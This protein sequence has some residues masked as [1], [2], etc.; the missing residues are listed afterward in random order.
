MVKSPQDCAAG[1][2]LIVIAVLAFLSAWPLPFQQGGGIGSGMLP[3]A[4]AILLGGLG[5]LVTF[6]AL[7]TNGPNLTRWSLRETGLILGGV[8]LFALTIRGF[9][10]PFGITIPALGLAVAGPL[11][12]L[13]TAQADRSTRFGEALVFAV[14]LT[15]A[16]IV[17]FRLLLRL[18]IPVFPPLLGY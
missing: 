2:L 7:V 11:S 15:F 1:L 9:A 6:G 17:L 12:I 18:P 16:C 4:T 13:V 14:L 5:A 8:M 10:L 3:K